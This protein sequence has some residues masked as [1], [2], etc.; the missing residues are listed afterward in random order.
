M[1]G[2]KYHTIEQP[3]K[4]RSINAVG[5]ESFH[6]AREARSLPASANLAIVK[7]VCE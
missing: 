4:E 2:A 5:Y 6:S 1:S 7:F 3:K